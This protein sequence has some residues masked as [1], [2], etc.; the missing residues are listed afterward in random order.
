MKI[1]IDGNDGSG[2]S[3]LVEKLRELGYTVKDRGIPTILTDNSSIKPLSDEFYFILDV[4]VH[5]SRERLKKAGKDLEEKYHT[6]EDL[7]FYRKRFLAVAEF[8]GRERCLLLNGEESVYTLLQQVQSKIEYRN[9][10]ENL[11]HP[12]DNDLISV[13][14]KV[15]NRWSF[16]IFSA[17]EHFR[18]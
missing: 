14:H 4:P 11:N 6:V 18:R 3:T 12:E 7:T 17:Y 1:V 9:Y 16:K 15:I 5:I 2:K 10:L 13:F 8:L